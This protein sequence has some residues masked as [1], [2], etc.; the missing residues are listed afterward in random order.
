MIIYIDN[1]EF[2]RRFREYMKN[3]GLS[4]EEFCRKTGMTETLLRE[5]EKDGEL[6]IPYEVLKKICCLFSIRP[7]DLLDV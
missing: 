1:P 3:S 7:E 4:R 5:L 2:C 6:D